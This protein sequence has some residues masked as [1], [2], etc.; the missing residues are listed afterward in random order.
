[1]TPMGIDPSLT[2]T[3]VAVRNAVFTI[4]SKLKGPARL[5]AIRDE[6]DPHLAGVDLVAI[7]GYAHGAPHQLAALGELGGV[8]RTAL[9]EHDIEYVD[10]APNTLKMYALGIGRGNKTEVVLAAHKRLGYEGA[11]DDEADALWLRAIAADLLGE[12]IVD[13]PQTHLRALTHTRKLYR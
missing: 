9:W 8:I 10:I 5:A 4:G 3:G 1:M 7:E 12:P 6:L 11:N 2:S 13:L